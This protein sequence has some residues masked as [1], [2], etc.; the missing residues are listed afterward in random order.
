MYA[1]VCVCV[2]R[3]MRSALSS[4]VKHLSLRT[5]ALLATPFLINTVYCAAKTFSL[6]LIF[7]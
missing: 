1:C 3:R 6:Y 5:T 2:C 7:I 4:G